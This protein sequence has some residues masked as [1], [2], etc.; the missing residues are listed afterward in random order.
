M[1]LVASER[2][3]AGMVLSSLGI[4]E[5]SVDPKLVRCC[6]AMAIHLWP[7]VVALAAELTKAPSGYRFLAKLPDAARTI[8]GARRG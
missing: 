6:S 7:P 3:P 8:R 5:A 2:V 4:G 1:G